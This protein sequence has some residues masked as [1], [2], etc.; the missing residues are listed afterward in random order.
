MFGQ[1]WLVDGA[2]VDG[3]PGVVDG[4]PGVVDGDPGV[5]VELDPLVAALEM[6][7][8]TPTPTP[9]VPPRTASPTRI[10]AKRLLI[11]FPLYWDILRRLSKQSKLRAGWEPPVT[12]PSG[13]FC[14][15]L[16]EYGSLRVCEPE[17][18]HSKEGR[19]ALLG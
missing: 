4:D 2:V 12:S 7:L 16:V 14:P 5:V 8:P 13:W 15:L 6:A 1:W 18:T 17:Q 19:T 3:D 10:S 11:L 9:T